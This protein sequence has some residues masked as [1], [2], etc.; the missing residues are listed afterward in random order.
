[1][2]KNVLEY[3]ENSTEKYP[4]KIAFADSAKAYAYS[5]FS[6]KAKEI[7]VEICGKTKEYNKPIA[8]FVDRKVESLIGFMAVLYSGNFYVPIDNKMPKQ[9]IESVIEQVNPLAVLYINEDETL[10][11]EVVSDEII[12]INMEALLKENQDSVNLYAKI[13]EEM[14]MERRRKI[15]DI[16]PVYVIFTSGSTGTPKGIVISHR[17]VIDFTDWMTETFKFSDKDIMGNQAP[18]YFDLSVK[19]IYTT[20]KCGATT[21]IIPKKVLMFP[22]LLI[23]YLNEKEVTSLIWATSAFNLVSTSKVLEKKVLNTVNKVILGGEA[24]LAK[25]LNNWKRAMPNIS[26]VNLYG[27]TEV[28]V[29]CTYYI[30]DREYSDE[31]AV[32]IGKA[33]ENK[34][35]LLLD[36]NLKP[37]EDGTAGEICV[38]GTG[39]AKGY[40]NDFEKTNTSFIQN[41]LNPYF[42]DII[43]KTGDIGIRNEE[44]LI[45]FQARK[46]GQIKHMGYRIELGEIER[47]LNSFEFITSAI[48]FYDDNNKKIVCIYEGDTTDAEI[49]KYIQDII[50][51]YMYPNIIRKCEKMP[52]NANGKIDRVKLKTEYY[53]N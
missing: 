46:D 34:E 13:N 40:F 25:H 50:P 31:E 19:D 10:V 9:R 49:I 38:R 32:P 33:C 39:V 28:T 27:P 2:Q 48:C 52:Y 20:M 8:V 17:S 24:L 21:H 35:V 29:D 7:A 3:L 30:I 36:E 5:E 4:N 42:P 45:V 1:M 43:Y 41:P 26:Y 53:K 12:K 16:D 15:L 23:D 11:N 37:V 18:F 51:K 14:L 44:G 22:T 6:K 47:A